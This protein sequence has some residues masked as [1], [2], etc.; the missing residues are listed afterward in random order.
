M[1]E[2]LVK[3][4]R[5]NGNWYPSGVVLVRACGARRF[6]KTPEIWLVETAGL[7]PKRCAGSRPVFR[8]V[9]GEE[10]WDSQLGQLGAQGKQWGVVRSIRRQLIHT[11]GGFS[12]ELGET[13]PSAAILLSMKVNNRGQEDEN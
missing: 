1:G 11:D 3:T 13:P 6:K 9:L 8:K 7:E 4:Q 2:G 12:R 5:E 10:I